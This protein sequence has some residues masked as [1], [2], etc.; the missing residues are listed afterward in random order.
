VRNLGKPVEL[1]ERYFLEGADEVTFLN[2]T[3]FRDFPLNDVPMLEVL[4][5]ASENIFVPLTVGGGIREFTDEN[6]RSYTALE[7]ASQ[8]FRR[9][10]CSSNFSC[11]PPA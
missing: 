11:L 5:S 9:A 10:I 1:A 7:V 8:Y 3:G 2:I 4:Q 6:G